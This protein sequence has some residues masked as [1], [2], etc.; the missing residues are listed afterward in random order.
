M[1]VQCG[2]LCF[3]KAVRITRGGASLLNTFEDPHLPTAITFHYGKHFQGASSSNKNNSHHSFMVLP[4]I[5]I[6]IKVRVML[7]KVSNVSRLEHK[8]SNTDSQHGSS[9]LKPSDFFSSCLVFGVILVPFIFLCTC[10][11]ENPLV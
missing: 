5:R 1:A 11:C 10:C 7:P 4:F 6:R 8:I 2:C 3:Q 9:M